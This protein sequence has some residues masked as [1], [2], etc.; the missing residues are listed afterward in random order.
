MEKFDRLKALIAICIIGVVM[1]SF[2]V[3]GKDEPMTRW[4]AVGGIII[5][6]ITMF[7]INRMKKK[8]Q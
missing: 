3:I 1:G 7:L 6:L 2:V 4:L 5:W 8:G